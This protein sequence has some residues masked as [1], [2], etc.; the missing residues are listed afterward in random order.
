MSE[1]EAGRLVVPIA[2]IAEAIEEGAGGCVD[3][4]TM[5]NERYRTSEPGSPLL[6]DVLLVLR[7]GDGAVS[8]ASR[9]VDFIMRLSPAERSRYPK[10]A[11]VHLV[12]G[13]DPTGLEVYHWPEF[14][15][16]CARLGIAWE[17]RTKALSITLTEDAVAVEQVYLPGNCTEPKAWV[18]LKEEYRKQ[19]N[20]PT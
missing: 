11:A 10:P 3:T 18:E 19:Q 9:L 4:T 6:E 16:L 1:V 5:Q 8:A 20:A 13:S 2:V 17:R 12:E 7:N 14:M 15:R